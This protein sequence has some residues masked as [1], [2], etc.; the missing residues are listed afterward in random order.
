MT[1]LNNEKIKFI[2]LAHQEYGSF[3]ITTHTEVLVDTT[4]MMMIE[5]I[6]LEC[7]TV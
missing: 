1:N 3:E 6:N 4:T 7:L 5:T 2:E